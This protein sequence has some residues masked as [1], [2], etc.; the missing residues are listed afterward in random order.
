VRAALSGLTTR[1][2]CLLAAGVAAALCGFALGERDLL[3]VAIFLIA[4]P[5]VAAAV[6]ART[7]FRLSCTRDLAP[8][9]VPAGQPA[10]ARLVL[11]NVSFLPTGLLLLEDEV[12]YT[13]GGRPRFT[14][15]RIGP[16]QHRTVHYPIRSD[17]RGRY[18][19][20]PLRLR[21]ADPF[22]LVELTRSF[23]A[24]DTLTVVP[25]VHPLPPV[26]LG[27][28]WESGG[29]SVSRSVAIRGDDDAATR[30][31]RNGDDLRKVHWR[32]TARVGKLM[33][34][35]EERPWQARATLLLD[36]RNDA[37][38][39]EGPGSSLEWAV[40]AIASIG[41]HAA[42]RGYSL[43]L[44]TDGGPAAGG[45][46]LSHEGVL[47]D[48]LA[49]IHHSRN[50]GLDAAIGPLRGAE[51]LGTLI[52]VTGILDPEQ[53]ALLAST[54]SPSEVSVAVL[55]DANGWLGLSP[56]A[57]AES[58]AAYDASVQVLLR[59]GWRVL[60]AGHG[61]RLPQLWPTAG[62]RPGGVAPGAPLVPRQN[63]EGSTAQ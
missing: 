48:H 21:L 6:V 58:E 3:R 40:S 61:D 29:E 53:A 63:V 1:G 9:R 28:A 46:E 38:R 2:R 59:A 22:G 50:R 20:G 52:A 35:R 37:H 33:V 19:I 4:L 56:R 43:R 39:G 57:Q 42:R 8:A 14:V 34:R 62:Q 30:E 23:T 49:E 17:A 11:E 45:A 44:I 18:K 12:P 60:R 54:R 5:L 36:T 13:L 51:G 25:A 24:V 7:R 10:T 32:S 27:G 31:Y 16:G 55:L 47:L 15:D 26:R 41:V